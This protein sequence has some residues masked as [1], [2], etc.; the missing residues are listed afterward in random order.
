MPYTIKHDPESDIVEIVFTG[1][2]ESD[3]M[4]E[5]TTKC[6][7]LQKQT[8]AT[9]FLVDAG[10]WD[11]AASLVDIFDLPDKQ[12]WKEELSRQTRVAVVRPTAASALKAAQFYEITCRNRGWNAKVCSDRQHAVDWLKGVGT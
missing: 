1:P 7:S 10:E 9:R 6:T 2:I 3:D 5:A 12:Y 4:I 8:G 11:V